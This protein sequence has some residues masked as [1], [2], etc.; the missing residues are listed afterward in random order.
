MR[1]SLSRRLELLETRVLPSK[2]EPLTLIIQFVGANGEVVSTMPVTLD[3]STAQSRNRG[4][5]R[6]SA[7]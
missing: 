3:R 1:R 4:S 7:C 6:T 2:E 5:H